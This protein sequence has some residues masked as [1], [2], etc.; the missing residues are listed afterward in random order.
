MVKIKL[1]DKIK[2][3]ISGLEGIATA[4]AIYLYGCTQYEVTPNQLHDGKPIEG[5]WID[6][7]Q[8][9]LV[10]DNGEKEPEP[11]YGGMRTHPR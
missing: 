11:V 10:K 3:R 2:D 4:K 6:E 1:G 8:L 9:E 5:I 7:P